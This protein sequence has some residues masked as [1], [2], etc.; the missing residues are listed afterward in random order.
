MYALPNDSIT[1]DLN[2]KYT[3][4]FHEASLASITSCKSA[5]HMKSKLMFNRAGL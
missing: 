5:R 4:L 1:S 3:Y 2:L